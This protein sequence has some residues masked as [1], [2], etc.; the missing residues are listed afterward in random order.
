MG[1]LL[2]PKKL[3]KG[4]KVALVNPTGKIPLKFLNQVD[5]SFSYLIKEGYKP[6]KFLVDYG[7]SQEQRAYMFN[8]AVRN[9]VKALFPVG[10]SKGGKDILN[11]IDYKELS[12]QKPI[13]AGFSSLSSLLAMINYKADLLVFYGPH[14]VFLNDN[15]S[16]KENRYTTASFWN[17]LTGNSYNRGLGSSLSKMIFR[18][19]NNPLILKNI[20][21][22][23]PNLDQEIKFEGY[24]SGQIEGKILASSLEGLI[25]L[26]EFEYSFKNKIII[27]DSVEI[28]F[29]ETIGG[30]KIILSRSDI[31]N[32]SAII[33]ASLKSRPDKNNS[34]DLSELY[35]ESKRK[36]FISTLRKMFKENT[37]ILYGFPSGHG[38][39]KLT[40]PLGLGALLDLKTGDLSLSESVFDT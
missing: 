6:E 8:L 4:D 13:F 38:R 26:S 11:F 22:Y 2:K 17:I 40:I 1:N 7:A 16:F 14:L 34:L 36:N 10:D 33:I 39:Y 15:A 3:S 18:S 20:H 24:E 9:S 19:G 21:Y 28:G 32:A 5:N 30:I 25:E 12:K 35:D 23:M 27:I 31:G 37:P 29:D